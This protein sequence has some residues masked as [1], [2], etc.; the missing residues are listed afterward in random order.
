M[1][2]SMEPHYNWYG[3]CYLTLHFTEWQCFASFNKYKKRYK[4]PFYF[5]EIATIYTFCN[6]DVC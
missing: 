4:C 2:V 6:I 3:K 5:A 1:A